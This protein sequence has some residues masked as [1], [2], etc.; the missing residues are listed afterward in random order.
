[1]KSKELKTKM[2]SHAHSPCLPEIK[3]AQELQTVLDTCPLADSL[4]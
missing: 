4:F 3:G 1:M 2:Y